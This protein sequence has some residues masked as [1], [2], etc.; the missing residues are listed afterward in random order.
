MRVEA[1]AYY[2][3]N[4]IKPTEF[5]NGRERRAEFQAREFSRLKLEMGQ[6]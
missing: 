2:N 6:P 3:Y 1:V 4:Y 5:W